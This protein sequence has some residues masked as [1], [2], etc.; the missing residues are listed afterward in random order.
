MASACTGVTEP[1]DS[2]AATTQS[3]LAKANDDL[4]IAELVLRSDV[5]VEWAVCF[6]AQQAAEKAVKAVLVH[7]GIDFPK[8]HRLDRL[9]GLLPAS[10]EPRFDMAALTELAPWAVAGRY[11]EDISNPTP[12]QASH[13]V[14]L[15]RAVVRL[16]HELVALK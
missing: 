14:E 9:A 7:A 6:H 11:P 13:V 10:S 5:G 12:T 3:W 8:S 16:A 2:S 4:T 1:S 15:A